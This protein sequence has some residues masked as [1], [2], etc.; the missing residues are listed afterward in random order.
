M[1]VHRLHSGWKVLNLNRL[2]NSEADSIAK[3]SNKTR[4]K[5]L[6]KSAFTR[7]SA[8]LLRGQRSNIFDLG[9]KE[10]FKMEQDVCAE[11]KR[12]SSFNV[13]EF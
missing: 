13:N 8:N 11:R 1:S 4:Y 12:D 5:I 6:L 3:I 9:P 2:V 10:R 7:T